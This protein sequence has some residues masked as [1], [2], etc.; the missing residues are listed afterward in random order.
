MKRI[1]RFL[2]EVLVEL[3]IRTSIYIED[4]EEFLPISQMESIREFTVRKDDFLT[5]G[6]TNLD[7][8]IVFEGNQIVDFDQSDEID[9][10]WN[11][12]ARTLLECMETG[13]GEIYF[14]NAPIQVKFEKMGKHYLKLTV[15]DQ[16][17][18]AEVTTLITTFCEAAKEFMTFR[19]NLTDGEYKDCLEKT[20]QK[21]LEKI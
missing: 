18:T 20:I 12:Y 7:G 2:S 8:K 3:E 1:K 6:F 19:N 10:L 14:P 21:L 9:P 11:Y 16:S 17:L 13:F 4:T 5:D 15:D